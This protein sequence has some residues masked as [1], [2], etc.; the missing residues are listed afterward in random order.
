VMSNLKTFIELGRP[1]PQAPW[2]MPGRR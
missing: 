2:E 1:L